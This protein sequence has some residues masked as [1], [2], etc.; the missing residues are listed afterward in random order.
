MY[1]VNHASKGQIP[2]KTGFPGIHAQTFSCFTIKPGKSSYVLDVNEKK[3][4]SYQ[5]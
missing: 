4:D 2:E 3:A 5:I 1:C